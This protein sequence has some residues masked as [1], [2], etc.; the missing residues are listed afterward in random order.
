MSTCVAS[1]QVTLSIGGKSFTIDDLSDKEIENIQGNG[2]STITI[3]SEDG[4]PLYMITKATEETTILNELLPEDNITTIED[5]GITYQ[6]I[7]F[8]D[9]TPSMTVFTTEDGSIYEIVYYN[10]NDFLLDY[11]SIGSQLNQ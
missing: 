1:S 11:K 5:N 3:N 4:K 9:G 8:S 10:G 7:V 2:T 6:N